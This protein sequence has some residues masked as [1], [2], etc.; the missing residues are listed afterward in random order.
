MT[1]PE[2]FGDPLSPVVASRQSKREM[3]RMEQSAG[4]ERVRL[5]HRQL[6]AEQRTALVSHVGVRA[7]ELQAKVSAHE[8]RLVE[9]EPGAVH[10]I[11]F[12]SQAVTFGLR[13]VLDNAIAE[14]TR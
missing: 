14:V 4:I 13:Q 6:L 9:F 11:S 12:L 2:R 8:R 1:L 5:M 3:F 10:G 7:M